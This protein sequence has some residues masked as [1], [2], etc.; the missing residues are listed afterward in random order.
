MDCCV[1]A[2][3]AIRK[4]CQLVEAIA[5]A[6]AWRLVTIWAGLKVVALAKAN[7]LLPARAVVVQ[8]KVAGATMGPTV[9]VL[10][11]EDAPR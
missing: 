8:R 2:L 6:A 1:C 7:T 9:P 10:Q 3:M 4:A 5:S 11:N